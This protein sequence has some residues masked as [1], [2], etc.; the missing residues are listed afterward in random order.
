VIVFFV[1]VMQI[2]FTSSSPV[3]TTQKGLT[4]VGQRR[5]TAMEVE[6]LM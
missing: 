1:D 2:Y 4:K 3:M 6:L 5:I